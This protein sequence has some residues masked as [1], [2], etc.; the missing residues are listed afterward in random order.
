M[1]GVAT[2][3]S[4]DLWPEALG[5]A[6]VV[7]GHLLHLQACVEGLMLN[8]VNVYTPTS[9]PEWVRFFQQASA[10]FGSLDPRECLVLGGDFNTTLE[11][12]NQVVPGHRRPPPGDC[13]SSLP[14]EC[15]A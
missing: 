3:F 13:G 4:H 2:L 9:G 5:V 10:F 7:L 15:L 6:K 12:W 14:D 1:T 8:L 11:K